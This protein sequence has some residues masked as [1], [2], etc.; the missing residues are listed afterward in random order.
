MLS[1]AIAGMKAGLA[2]MLAGQATAATALPPAEHRATL[3]YGDYD[4][5]AKQFIIG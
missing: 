2:A 5:A 1:P 3:G 4:A